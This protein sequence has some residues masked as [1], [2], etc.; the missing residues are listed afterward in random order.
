M[1][2][3]LISL[4]SLIGSSFFVQ[5]SN[6]AVITFVAII[7]AESGGTQSDVALI[8][9]AYSVGF[10]LGCFLAPP[11]IFRI[12]L[13][14]GYAAAAGVMTIAIVALE[15]LDGIAAL[16]V[17]RFLMGASFAAVMAIADSWINDK[18]PSDQRG[19]ILAVYSVFLGLASILS[20]VF[21]L[22][23]DATEDGF[24]LTFAISMNMA[25]VLVALGTTK[26]PKLGGTAPKYL[27]PLSFVSTP[28]TIAAFNSGFCTTAIIAITP[29]Y[30]AEHGVDE[31]LI[32]MVIGAI[33]LGRLACQWP[34]GLISDRLDRRT[35]LFA[36]SVA[37]I[38]LCF[39]S[40]LVG[41]G[42]GQNITGDRGVL[43]QALGFLV[44][45][46]LGGALYPMYSV[47][48]AL[49][50]DR[51]E[52]RSMMEISTTMLVV[53]SIGAIMGPIAVI[54]L[55]GFFGDFALHVAS[56]FTCAL[57]A[58]SC[59]VGKAIRAP[60]ESPTKAVASVTTNSVGMAETS[61]EIVEERIEEQSTAS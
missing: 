10:I 37:V 57:V 49:A 19:R 31:N 61:A 54:F 24:V 18:A 36:L 45:F 15:L 41:G 32:A 60:A 6:A 46:A 5:F 39:L 1:R 2:S 16:T 56:M 52:G 8:A 25:V 22:T 34:I 4:A 14:R 40:L 55:S 35:L 21:F 28:A 3:I 58:V 51:A 20:Q 42:Q 29:F 11:Q 17:L 26:Q 7:I 43:V 27:R 38:A 33:Y 47:A 23:L 12:G 30:L 59:V 13:V 48:A 44:S 9:S 53:H 50:F